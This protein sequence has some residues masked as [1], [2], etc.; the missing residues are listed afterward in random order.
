MAKTKACKF[1]KKKSDKESG[2]MVNMSFFCNF[3][4]AAQHGIKLSLASKKRQSANKDKAHKDRKKAFRLS[5]T[6]HQHKLTQAVFNKLRVIQE[7]KWFSDRG[8][9]PVCISCDKPNMDWCC[10]HFKSRG[11]QGNLRYDESNT[12]LQCNRYCNM[13]LSGN[14]SGNKTT[15]GYIQGLHDRFGNEKAKEIIDYCESNK[16]TKKWTGE[17]LAEMRAEFNRLIKHHETR[18]T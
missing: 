12:F 17:E 16:Q 1:C 15:R 18:I 9:E 2:V 5:D 13:A 6:N 8:L 14:I 4:C 3:K 10:G 11:S 7:K